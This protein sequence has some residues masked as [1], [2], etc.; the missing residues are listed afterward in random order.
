MNVVDAASKAEIDM[1]LAVLLAK[2]FRPLYAN[3]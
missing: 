2:K 1:I 3:I